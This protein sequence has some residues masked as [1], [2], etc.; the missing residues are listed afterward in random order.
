MKK[1]VAGLLTLV[2]VFAL[3]GCGDKPSPYI[4]GDSFTW[5][6]DE[7]ERNINDR[8]EE[9]SEKDNLSLYP[10]QQISKDAE[11]DGGYTYQYNQSGHNFYSSLYSG[12]DD[13]YYVNFYLVTNAENKIDWLFISIDFQPADDAQT[14]YEENKE[15]IEAYF[16]SFIRACD[17]T[18]SKGDAKSIVKGLKL[19]ITD[20]YDAANPPEVVK[21]SIE[22][23]GMET[24][25]ALGITAAP[26]SED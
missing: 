19:N 12:T 6:P 9:I 11:E 13:E 3:A 21:H 25:Y 20:D 24:S 1:V 14:A 4:D 5:T 23:L 7:F 18:L 15:E 22:F 16:C 10:F 2:M 26:N 8:I 17:D